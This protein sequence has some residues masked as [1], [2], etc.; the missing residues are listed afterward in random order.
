M[1]QPVDWSQTGVWTPAAAG[2]QTRHGAHTDG[3]STQV[4]T[5]QAPDAHT[6]PGAHGFDAGS[7]AAAQSEPKPSGEQGSTTAWQRSPPQSASPA[8]TSRGGTPQPT[9]CVSG[10]R[11]TA[12]PRQ[13]SPD[14]H[15]APA[16]DAPESVPVSPPPPWQ[17]THSA[18][19]HPRRPM[20]TPTRPYHPV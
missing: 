19:H 7:Q 11:Q 12:S 5:T 17:A 9:A 20:R 3:W 8:Q 4:S 18:S 16:V 10:P 1:A 14:A 13:T 2:S 15:G 6:N